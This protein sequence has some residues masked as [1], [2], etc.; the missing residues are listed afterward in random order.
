MTV[1]RDSVEWC[2]QGLASLTKVV[3]PAIA[4]QYRQHCAGEQEIV[5]AQTVREALEAS[6][7][8][9][10]MER[11]LGP[12]VAER[13]RR[14]ES[15]ILPWV[16]RTAKSGGKYLKNSLV[17]LRE[18]WTAHPP[19]PIYF[20]GQRIWSKWTDEFGRLVATENAKA[21]DD[22]GFPATVIGPGES[23]KYWR[24]GFSD[25]HDHPCVPHTA[26]KPRE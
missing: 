4:E 10:W 14:I 11:H 19:L 16:R 21:G 3:E 12:E 7:G 5:S 1:P 18:Q 20:R 9:A 8:D 6:C 13:E 15:A 17:M 2:K 24:V 22:R 26:I 25:G 23:D